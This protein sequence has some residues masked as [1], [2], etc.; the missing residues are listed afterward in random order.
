MSPVRVAANLGVPL[1]LAGCFWALIAT[2]EAQ[3]FAEWVALAAFV[4][5]LGLWLGFRDLAA[6]ASA[7][8]L[9]GAG[10]PD[11]LLTL[12]KQQAAVHAS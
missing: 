11:E 8:R 12:A 9:L 6:K 7:S 1:L 3:G 2:S 4:I 5:V 10:L